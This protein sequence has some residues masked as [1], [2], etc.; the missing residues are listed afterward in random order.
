MPFFLDVTAQRGRETRI[1]DVKQI[2]EVFSTSLRRFSAVPRDSPERNA[3]DYAIGIFLCSAS[4]ARKREREGKL[5]S[6]N[7]EGEGREK[8]ALPAFFK[9]IIS[10]V[11]LGETR[12]RSS[13]HEISQAC[14]TRNYNASGI[15]E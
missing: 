12:D 2:D 11:D 10:P 1:I 15:R 8:G 13:G 14:H 4:L 7:G 5:A 6:A 3:F 9:A